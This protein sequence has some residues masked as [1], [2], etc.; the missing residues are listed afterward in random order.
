MW[1]GGGVGGGGGG[2]GLHVA[3]GPRHGH[4]DV[5]ST[6][7]SP[8]HLFLKEQHPAEHRHLDIRAFSLT[9]YPVACAGRAQDTDHSVTPP[10][11]QLPREEN[12]RKSK[13]YGVGVAY[14]RL[15]ASTMWLDVPSSTA[16]VFT[17]VSVLLESAGWVMVGG[18]C[19]VERRG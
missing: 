19:I 3:R 15:S 7:T 2:E 17:S 1:V 8:L 11:T 12:K 5:M 6:A 10:P 13:Q 14:L 4:D 16:M 9:P 18:H